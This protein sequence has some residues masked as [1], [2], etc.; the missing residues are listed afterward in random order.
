MDLENINLAGL[1][2]D[3]NVQLDMLNEVTK[4]SGLVPYFN[5]KLKQNNME[6]LKARSLDIFQINVGKLCN[7]KC[8]HCHVDAGPDRTELMTRQI[9]H[10]CLEVI[11][12]YNFN[13][14]DITGGAPE[15]NPN[16]RWFVE[17]CTKINKK[18]IVRCN[19]TIMENEKDF[20][21]LP[22]FFKQHQVEVVSSLP[23]YNE[24]RTDKMRGRGVFESSINGLRKLN[25]VGYGMEGSNLVLDLVYNPAGAFLPAAQEMLEKEFKQELL[26][27]YGIRFNNLFCITNM[28][29]SRF[30]DHLIKKNNLVSY[31]E[32]LVSAFNVQASKS[33]MCRD[34]VSISWDGNMYDCDFNQMLDMKV[35]TGKR[36]HVSEFNFDAMIN[37]TIVTSQHCYGCT[38]G[39]GSSCGG[40]TV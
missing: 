37:R 38:A 9:M 39:A 35:D 6:K 32:T 20:G 4:Q 2:M 18:I 30:L 23:F 7:Q 34:M 22:V 36:T 25:S 8:K 15:M 12:K 24:V 13:T 14:V 19:L 1:S 31:M 5:D 16:F 33:V 26:G 40:A 10:Q 3:P 17:E 28:P 21:D 29:I 11:E 27:K